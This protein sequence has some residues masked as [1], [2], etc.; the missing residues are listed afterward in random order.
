MSLLVPVSFVIPNFVVGLMVLSTTLSNAS[1][2]AAAE[3][4]ISPI[5]SYRIV[6]YQR[7]LNYGTPTYTYEIYENPSRLPFVWKE[8]AHGTDPCG[9]GLGAKGLQIGTGPNDHVVV[10]SCRNPEPGFSSNQ[11]PI[12]QIE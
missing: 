3:G 6:Q 4:R 9:K 8:V 1:T 11:I 2:A 5:A 12:G 7:F 10:V